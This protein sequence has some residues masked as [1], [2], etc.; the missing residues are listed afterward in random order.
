MG[1]WGRDEVGAGVGGGDRN[2]DFPNWKEKMGGQR[3]LAGKNGGSQNRLSEKNKI[4]NKKW[5]N[6]GLLKQFYFGVREFLSKNSGN[7][8]FRKLL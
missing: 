7:F 3:F 5:G 8:H 6:R 1:G 2:N 4:V